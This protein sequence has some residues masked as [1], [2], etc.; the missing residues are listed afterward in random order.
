METNYWFFFNVNFIKPKR[1]RNELLF[2]PKHQSNLTSL[3]QFYLLTERKKYMKSWNLLKFKNLS[4]T[5]KLKI[6]RILNSLS[7]N[8]TKWSNILKQFVGNFARS[9][10][11]DLINQAF[12]S[13]Y[14]ILK[15]NCG[16]FTVMFLSSKLPLEIPA[17][18]L[19]FFRRCI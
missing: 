6:H 8:I 19:N 11:K 4:T 18:V 14:N 12:A 2:N 9:A 17:R 1:K 15:V 13:N 3:P 7:T 5:A 16:N 10:L